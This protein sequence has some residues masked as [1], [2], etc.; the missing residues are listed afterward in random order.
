M[1][2]TKTS[3]RL[4]AVVKQIAELLRNDKPAINIKLFF[5]HLELSSFL[6]NSSGHS[7]HY[8]SP[9]VA[10]QVTKMCIVQTIRVQLHK[11]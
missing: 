7:K 11:C 2:V 10:F 8:C 1:V 6:I 9:G 5:I 4:N 3:N